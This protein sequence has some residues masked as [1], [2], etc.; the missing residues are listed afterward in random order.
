MFERYLLFFALL[1]LSAVARAELRDPTKPG[2]L[3]AVQQAAGGDTAEAGLHLTAIWISE[4]GRRA[5]ING[6]TVRVGQLL[7]DG[8]RVLKIR[9]NDVLIRRNGDLIKVHLVPSVK[10]AVK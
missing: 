4:T 5:V 7:P 3:P 10:K 8:S 2:N 1:F 6:N 9:Q